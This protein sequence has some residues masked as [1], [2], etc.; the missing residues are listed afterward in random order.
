MLA[1]STLLAYTLTDWES[2]PSGDELVF[3][4]QYP[5]IELAEDETYPP[6][7]EAYPPNDDEIDDDEE[8]DEPEDGAT[9][10]T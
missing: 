6:C 3:S 9:Q 10:A 7:D 1:S 8:P 2:L 4:E 5:A